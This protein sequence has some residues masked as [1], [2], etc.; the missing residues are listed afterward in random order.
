MLWALIP[1]GVRTHTDEALQH[2]SHLCSSK[3]R[4]NWKHST[5]LKG[6]CRTAASVKGALR[7]WNWVHAMKLYLGS[8][9]DRVRDSILRNITTV[10]CCTAAI[11]S[12]IPV[13]AMHAQLCCAHFVVHGFRVIF[14]TNVSACTTNFTHKCPKTAILCSLIACVVRS[15]LYVTFVWPL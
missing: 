10:C 1:P 7:W 8:G 2:K 5:Y 14:S 3:A 15:D 6:G 4:F 11:F 9:G 13:W 12:V